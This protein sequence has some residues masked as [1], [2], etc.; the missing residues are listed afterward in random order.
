[1][2]KIKELKFKVT[3]KN[4]IFG[5]ISI[6]HLTESEMKNGALP[7]ILKSGMK[8]NGYQLIDICKEI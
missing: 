4:D 8:E 3:F 6:F 7:Q 1:M 5:D 2:E